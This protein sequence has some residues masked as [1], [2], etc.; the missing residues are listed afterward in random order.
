MKYPNQ[1]FYDWDEYY[2]YSF[3]NDFYQEYVDAVKA[4]Q[5]KNVTVNDNIITGE[6]NYEKDG[7]TIF[8]V[9]YSDK[10]HAYIDGE[11]VDTYDL[12]NA[13]LIIKTPA[14]KHTIKLVYDI[15][16]QV[17]VIVTSLAFYVLTFLIYSMQKL[18]LK[19]K[20]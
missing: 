11:E 2:C 8:S 15:K 1:T 14:G 20:K 17:I 16:N 6:S 18:I 9:P 7:Y 10:W 13:N 12:I 3:N 5:V 19:R 4:N